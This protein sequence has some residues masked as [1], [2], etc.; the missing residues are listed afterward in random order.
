MATVAELK[1]G[2]REQG[3]FFGGMRR[4]LEGWDGRRA[5]GT[6]GRRSRGSFC[7]CPAVPGRGSGREEAV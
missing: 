7:W 1:A 5:R 2:E 6:Q 4:L 3:R